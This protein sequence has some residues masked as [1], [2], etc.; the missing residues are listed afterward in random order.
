[1]K[2]S[3]SFLANKKTGLYVH[4]IRFYKRYK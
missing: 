1:M 2:K 3:K 4:T